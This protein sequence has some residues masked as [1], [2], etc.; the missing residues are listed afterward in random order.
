MTHTVSGTRTVEALVSHGMDAFGKESE[1][2]AQ[3]VPS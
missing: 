1:R 3:S 2:G